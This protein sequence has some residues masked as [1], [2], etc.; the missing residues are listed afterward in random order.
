MYIVRVFRHGE[1]FYLN[2]ITYKLNNIA[3]FGKTN[4][5]K[6]VL[7]SKIKYE[8]FKV[9]EVGRPEIINLTLL[10][11]MIRKES[12]RDYEKRYENKIIW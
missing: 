1:E 4:V 8:N 6:S 7:I 12:R 10:K 5:F 9:C 2:R 11:K 3:D